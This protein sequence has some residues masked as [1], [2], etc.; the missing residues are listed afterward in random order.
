MMHRFP[1]TLFAASVLF[2]ACS[3]DQELIKTTQ[4]TQK[5]SNTTQQLAA[6][7]DS[8]LFPPATEIQDSTTAIE[9]LKKQ[10]TQPEGITLKGKWSKILENGKLQN[11]SSFTFS[12]RAPSFLAFESDDARITGTREQM[13]MVMKADGSYAFFN[14]RGVSTPSLMSLAAPPAPF[15][16]PWAE[17]LDVVANPKLLSTASLKEN[18]LVFSSADE[19]QT[20]ITIDATGLLQTIVLSSATNQVFLVIEEAIPRAEESRFSLTPPTAGSNFTEQFSNAGIDVEQQKLVGK[21]A[22][23]FELQTLSGERVRLSELKGNVVVLDFWATWCPPCVEALPKLMAVQQSTAEQPVRILPINLDPQ[24]ELDSR[25]IPFL[26]QRNLERLTVYTGAGEQL[27]A[28]YA[29]DA[30]PHIV[31]V[32]PEGVVERVLVGYE[33]SEPILQQLISPY[34]SPTVDSN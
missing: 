30:L 24:E 25:V 8:V 5:K 19:S 20:E 16:F 13:L 12:Y 4:S 17:A 28:D 31:I 21:K 14:G 26:K 1:L 32:N 15:L 22:P 29:V 7:A 3:T 18:A 2:A 23:D 33:M 6:G 34:L 11:P 27:F 9:A 10:F